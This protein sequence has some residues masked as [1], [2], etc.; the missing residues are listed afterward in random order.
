MWCG[1]V[2]CGVPVVGA[3]AAGAGGATVVVLGF[4]GTFTVRGTAPAMLAVCV[5]ANKQERLSATKVA[6]FTRSLQPSHTETQALQKAGG[7]IQVIP[8]LKTFC[9]VATM[10]V[11]G[12]MTQQGHSIPKGTAA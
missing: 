4:T 9:V 10:L 2:W 3:A 6:L 1:V 11:M 12:T 8:N 7:E 5:S